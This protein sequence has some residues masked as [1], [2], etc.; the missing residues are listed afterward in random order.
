MLLAWARRDQRPRGDR[1]PDVLVGREITEPVGARLGRKASAT[2]AL[3]YRRRRSIS[4]SG[5]VGE[6]KMTA[7]TI[8]CLVGR[9]VSPASYTRSH[10]CLR[11]SW[12]GSGTSWPRGLAAA[13]TRRSLGL[14][15]IDTSPS[16]GKVS[17][18]LSS[19][20]KQVECLPK[21]C[22]LRPYLM[23]AR[24]LTRRRLTGLAATTTS[25]PPVP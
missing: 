3:P 21:L 5:V 23:P 14:N 9:R 8:S 15:L 11:R 17:F 10:S 6:P 12:M 20:Q 24:L 1:G 4:S 16:E 25:A 13:S 2:V 22:Q 7:A 18:V 19:S